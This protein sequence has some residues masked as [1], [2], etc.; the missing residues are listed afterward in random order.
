MALAPRQITRSTDWALDCTVEQHEQLQ[1]IPGLRYLPHGTVSGTIDAVAVCCLRLGLEHPE[2]TKKGSNNELLFPGDTLRPYQKAGVERLLSIMRQVGG[3]VL[4]DDV[5]LGKTRQAHALGKILGGRKLAIVPAYVR[6]SWREELAKLGEK[7]ISVISPGAS[8]RDQAEWATCI[9]SEW[10]ICSYD[11]VEKVSQVAFTGRPPD[12]V[13][14]DE[15]HY[16]CGRRTK[17]SVTVENICTL[18]TYKLLMTATPMYSRPRDF[19]RPLKILFGHRF[20]SPSAFDFAYC[21]GSLNTWGGIENKGA[22]N[23]NELRLRL[24][25]YMIRREKKDVLKE[26]PPLTRQVMWLDPSKEAASVFHK[27]MTHKTPG[28]ISEALEATLAGKMDTAV[29]LAIQ[30]RRFLLF[31]H[32]RSHA[33]EMAHQLQ[34]AGTPCV[35]ITGDMDTKARAESCRLAQAQGWGVVATIDSLG[36]GVNLQGVA[37]YGIMH[38][39]DWIPLKMVQAEGRLHRMGQLDP[40]QW[41]YLAMSGTMDEVVVRTVIEKLDQWRGVMGQHDQVDMRNALD[42]NFNP[43]KNQD[44]LR[45]IYEAM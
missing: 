35:C 29:E 32:R 34:Q 12:M 41:V 20:G 4:A 19:Y 15:G 33:R 13:L 27:Q 21:A 11:M 25:Y 7:S 1:D 40:V 28:G 39:I 5:G 17:R 10:V 14:M 2:F 24:S 23:E 18:T 38:S 30:V 37:S 9:S 8:K 3:A 42:D 16:L 31:T 22:S 36:A 43:E 44:V 45:A 6:E 26:L